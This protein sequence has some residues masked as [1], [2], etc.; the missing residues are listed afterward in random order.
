MQRLVCNSFFLDNP[1]FI[2]TANES[3]GGECSH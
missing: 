3:K 1:I 2:L